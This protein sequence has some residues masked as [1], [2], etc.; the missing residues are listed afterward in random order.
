MSAEIYK[1]VSSTYKD[2]YHYQSS[3][4]CKPKPRLRFCLTYMK[5]AYHQK[6]KR[7]WA[8]WCTPVIF[9]QRQEDGEFQVS[10]GYRA[11]SSLRKEKGEEKKSWKIEVRVPVRCWW[12]FK[13]TL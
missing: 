13:M 8:G 10:L 1:G 4:K 7:S 6:Q 2:G 9:Q 12:G 5:M 11:R 3:E